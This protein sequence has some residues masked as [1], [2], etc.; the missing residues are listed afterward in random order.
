LLH[1]TLNKCKFYTKQKFLK[2]RALYTLG[3]DIGSSSIKAALF[4]VDSGKELGHSTFPKDEME[5]LSP[6]PGWAE[7]E[8]EKWW[9]A[10]KSATKELLVNTRINPGNVKAIGLSY[11]MHGLVL[12][13]K[14]QKVLRPSII[15]CDSRAV[16]IGNRSFEEIG[17]DKCLTCLLNSPGNFTA[18]KFKWVKDNEPR[19][20]KKID[21]FM[22]PGDF[23]ALKLSG[24]STTTSTGLSEGILWNFAE[25]KPADFLM[26]HYGID[27][28]FIPRIVPTFGEQCL[29]SKKASEELGLKEGTPITYRAGDQPNN[30]FSLNVLRPNEIASTAGTSGVIYGI[31]D[32]VKFDP[33]GRVNTFIHVNH[34][35]ESK[36]LGILLCVNGTG[37]SYNWIR[38]ILFNSSIT[39]DELNNLAEQVS[40]GSAGLVFLPFG[41]GAERLLYNRELGASFEGINFIVHNRNHIVRAVIEGVAFSFYYGIKILNELA[42]NPKVIRAGMANMYLNSTFRNIIASLSE[43]EIQLYNTDGALGAARAAAYGAGFYSTFD[44]AFKDLECLTTVQPDLKNLPEYQE[45]YNKWE[46]ELLNKLKQ[47]K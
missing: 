10:V 32:E 29:L 1:I 39:Y 37:I 36:R 13:D 45:A 31:S 12:V 24:E 41:N 40:T 38:K 20:F 16:Q 4:D 26:T 28:S 27:E 19:I 43:A 7:Q 5:I 6:F 2:G 14:D 42:V 17:K 21:K 47:D 23:V 34:T 3:F 25:D 15:W 9:E 46:T 33:E 22:L 11:Q 30:A 8:P 44:E 35:T 18:S